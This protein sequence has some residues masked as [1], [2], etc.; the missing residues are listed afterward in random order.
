L[1]QQDFPETAGV[2][3]PVEL[4]DLQHSL[5][6]LLKSKAL[7]PQTATLATTDLPQLGAQAPAHAHTFAAPTPP[8]PVSDLQLAPVSH[9]DAAA[10]L[11]EDEWEVVEAKA[12]PAASF[13]GLSS[14]FL[15]SMQ[16]A[17]EQLGY[18]LTSSTLMAQLAGVIW[19]RLHCQVN[20]IYSD[21]DHLLF[22]FDAAV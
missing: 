2:L 1:H 19:W 15:K 20:Q 7:P 17:L 16:S 6:G 21:T 22:L 12:K 18:D 10:P 13:G 5:D 11:Q 9:P 14:E 3:P 4:S 8:P